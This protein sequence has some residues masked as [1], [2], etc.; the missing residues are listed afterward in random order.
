MGK[1]DEEAVHRKGDANGSWKNGIK[2]SAPSHFNKRIT[3]WNCN[4]MPAWQGYGE[5]ETLIL[6]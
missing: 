2:V 4:E 1:G 6:Y 5:R 3:N